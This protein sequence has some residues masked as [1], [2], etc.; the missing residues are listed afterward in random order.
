M[1]NST[2]QFLSIHG[3]T[4][5]L[6]AILLVGAALRLS[7]IRFDLPAVYHPDEDALV[8]PAMNILKTGDWNPLRMDY[9]SLVIYLQVPVL[10]LV[11]LLVA[12]TGVITSP[13]ELN[14]MERGTFPGI[15][16]HPEYVLAGRLLSTAFGMA[17]IVF[18]YMLGARLGSRRL[19]LIAAALAA[20][21]PDLVVHS[22]YATADSIMVSLS[23]L[24]IYLLVRA[25][26]S[27]STNSA[28]PYVAA[29]FVCGL[30]T[31]AKMQ[32]ALLIVP[33]L[34]VPLLRVRS[35][36]EVLSGRVVGGVLAM[37]AG[38]LLVTPF[39]ILD[40]PKYLEFA[41]L[42]LRIYAQVG[43]E[44]Q[45]TTWS[46]QLDT[47]FTGRNAMLMVA[48]IPGFVLSWPR[49]GW[50][51]L[52][53]NSFAILVALVS[54]TSPGRQTRTWLPMAPIVCLWAAL[55]LDWVIDS[56]GRRVSPSPLY[57]S[58]LAVFSVAL[59]MVPLFASAV[60]GNRNLSGEDVRT[61][62]QHWLEENVPP[63]EGVAF[64]RFWSNIDPNV[65]P[66]TLVFGHFGRDLDW[67]ASR[68]VRYVVASDV[69]H[70]AVSLSPEEEA[71]YEKLTGQMCLVK[72]FNGRFLAADDRN[73]WIYQMPPCE[74]AATP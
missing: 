41:S 63:G 59:V 24:A 4:L 3:T 51:A 73:Y 17:T 22:H 50:R 36:D 14:I 21:T 8:M 18:V 43:H 20:L 10:A 34:L 35:L 49:W 57:R 72:H 45:M 55:A 27:W 28:W 46:W 65:W 66:V 68:G 37:A 9:G 74:A 25:Y 60:A 40:T 62:V 47:W 39:A 42:V 5:V 6:A 13:T 44:T 61:E 38:F 12:R 29:G 7:A 54:L 52:V 15:F 30:A 58:G 71:S 11:Y 56:L 1:S 53:V 70:S 2:R 23:T 67:Y 16:P 26:D 31:A 69:I 33:L 48:A 32:G 19:G 64:D